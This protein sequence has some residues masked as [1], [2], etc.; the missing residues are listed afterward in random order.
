MDFSQILAIIWWFDQN[1]RGKVL[2]RVSN[3]TARYKPQKN[4]EICFNFTATGL[5]NFNKR[6][7]KAHFVSFFYYNCKVKC[8]AHWIQKPIPK[9]RLQNF[10]EFLSVKL[11]LIGQKIRENLDS[12]FGIGCLIQWARYLTLL[13][14]TS[15]VLW[16]I[17]EKI[18]SNKTNEKRKQINLGQRLSVKW[19]RA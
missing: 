4:E 14:V 17:F 1:L 5:S 16:R 10:Y 3:Q 2:D 7:L 15:T 9:I 8:L 13:C 11:I 12:H 18:N 19:K 6:C